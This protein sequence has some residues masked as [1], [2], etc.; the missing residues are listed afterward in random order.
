MVARRTKMAWRVRKGRR[1]TWARMK[2]RGEAK[3]REV[4]LRTELFCGVAGG[5][6]KQSAKL[7]SLLFVG[8]V[9]H[10]EFNA[11]VVA[12]AMADYPSG[13]NRSI[14]KRRRKFNQDFVRR[15][16]FHSS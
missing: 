1:L 2:R 10:N 5:Q 7:F 13:A 14:G 11:V 9:L 4:I 6:T 15:L 8:V 12:A 16:K 3:D